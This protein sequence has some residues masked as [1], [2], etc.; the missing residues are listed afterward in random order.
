[1]IVE[2]V[3]PIRAVAFHV[4][5]NCGSSKGL[6][7]VFPRH[8]ILKLQDIPFKGFLPL[9]LLDLLPDAVHNTL[10]IALIYDCRQFAM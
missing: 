9:E 5:R 2:S 3:W 7:S 8:C 10:Y 4:N 6:A 1:M